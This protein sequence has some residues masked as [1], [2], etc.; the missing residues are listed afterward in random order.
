MTVAIEPLTDTANQA[1]VNDYLPLARYLS[2]AV[3]L[4]VN[5][6][7]SRELAREMV[8]TRSGSHDI[9]MGSPHVVASAVRYGYVPVA[10][11]T[12]Q[13]T[14]AF[15]TL[16]KSGIKSLEELRG[17]RLGLPSVESL[18]SFVALGELNA[19]KLLAKD[20]GVTVSHY[21]YHDVA[22]FALEKGFVDAVA[23]DGDLAKAAA[24]ANGWNIYFE[25]PAVR[26]IS[27]AVNGQLPLDAQ[28]R[29][30]TALLNPRLA[31]ALGH[32]EGAAGGF[33]PVAAGDFGYIGKLTYLTPAFLPGANVIG[34][35]KVA[36]LIRQGVLCLDV[37]TEAEYKAH[38]ISGAKFLPYAEHSKKEVGFDRTQDKFAL[39]ET[40]KDKGAPIIFSCN[41]EECWKSYKAATWA[42]ADGYQQ[43]YWF[44]GGFPEWR[45]RNFALE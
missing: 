44:R 35:D 36:D 14:V 8:A 31:S 17:K 43:V 3:G 45:K 13:S 33:T 23:V 39:G 37:R 24:R 25:S 26:R 29:L 2:A 34:A 15:V 7:L 40:V 11:P 1:F 22:L 38:H 20:A 19:R 4:P 27:V 5:A 28:F 41:G 12:S 16:P 30:R 42:L 18:A 6:T 10:G 9:I 32:A 21:R